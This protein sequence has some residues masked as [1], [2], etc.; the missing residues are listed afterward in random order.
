MS[1]NIAGFNTPSRFGAKTTIYN[2]GDD[3]LTGGNVTRDASSF[4]LNLS[5]ET[6]DDPYNPVP[7]NLLNVGSANY[8][9]FAQGQ[10]AYNFI[11]N[12]STETYNPPR[13]ETYQAAG[14]ELVPNFGNNPSSF[15]ILAGTNQFAR[16][17]LSEVNTPYNSNP[18]PSSGWYYGNSSSGRDFTF[19]TNQF[20]NRLFN[21]NLPTSQPD[22]LGGKGNDSFAE[23]LINNAYIL[24]DYL[25][26][27]DPEEIQAYVK[28]YNSGTE[29]ARELARQQ[30]SNPT[31]VDQ[32]ILA[33]SGL[34]SQGGA[35]GQGVFTNPF[36]QEGFLTDTNPY[37]QYGSG[38]TVSNGNRT[39]AVKGTYEHDTLIGTQNKKNFMD[40]QGGEDDIVGG[41]LTDL[42]N[43]YAGDSVHA[44]AGNDVIIFNDDQAAYSNRRTEI[45]GGQ[46]EDKLIVSSGETPT[47]QRLAN[48]SIR[49]LLGYTEILAKNIEQFI[50]TDSQ[51]NVRDI[52][53][54]KTKN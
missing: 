9:F 15:K 26:S 52:Y 16:D 39:G 41:K 46:G 21:M 6:S 17:I 1:M 48:N 28:D 2:S 7:L 29:R 36:I 42:I 37:E 43:T 47:F 35:Y 3:F 8:D 30:F 22:N 44:E 32:A 5:P 45:D 13:V 27:N 49:I 33:T 20:A 34:K 18:S 54:P 14:Y 25:P 4:A 40:S 38:I 24:P 12:L 10:A 51:G 19:L 50:F 31:Q 11:R 53:E 23:S